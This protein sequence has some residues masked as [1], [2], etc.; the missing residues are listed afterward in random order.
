MDPIG[1]QHSLG[2]STITIQF[3]EGHFVDSYNPTIEN[4]FHKTIKFKGVE[5]ET[6]IIDTAGQVRYSLRFCKILRRLHIF[7][8][9][10]RMNIPFSKSI[11]LLESMDTF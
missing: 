3:V 4:T 5:Y 2:K 8:N 10:I 1:S 7:P 9:L 6:D 11:M